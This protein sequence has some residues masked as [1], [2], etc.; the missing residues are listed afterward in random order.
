ME[1]IAPQRLDPIVD[2]A[3]IRA[4]FV[5]PEYAR[6]GLGGLILD[7]AEQAA[8]V[9]GFTQFEMGS[10]LT[11]ASLYERKGYREM[12]RRKVPVG[13]GEAIEVVRMVKRLS[14]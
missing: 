2:A 1:K 4:I 10:T 13:G 12:E 9:E 8:I 7:A 6:M 5:H 14:L 3:K 11:G